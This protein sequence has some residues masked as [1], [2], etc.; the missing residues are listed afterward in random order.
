LAIEGE[1][2]SRNPIIVI[3]VMPIIQSDNPSKAVASLPS[4]IVTDLGTP[5]QPVAKMRVREATKA[6]EH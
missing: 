6:N 2:Y 5:A 4:A 3:Y 1:D